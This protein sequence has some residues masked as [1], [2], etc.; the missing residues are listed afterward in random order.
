MLVRPQRVEQH[1]GMIGRIQAARQETLSAP[2]E[3]VIRE[4]LAQEGQAIEAG[5]TLLRMD[6][7]QIEIQVRQAQAELLKAQREAH[8]LRN[9]DNS[10]E[11]FRARH[12][13]QN[14]R[15]ALDVAQANLRDTRALFERGI[16]A[17]M[18]VDTLAQQVR[19]QQQDF[20]I[21]GDELRTA[22]AR[23]KGMRL[24]IAEMELTN[25]QA[26]Y[27]AVTKQRERQDLKAPFAGVVV[28]PTPQDGSKAII[29]QPGLQVTQG[30]PLLTVIGLDRIQVLARVEEA[31]LHQLL[32]GM[33][34]QITGDGFP[35]QT[36]AGRIATIAVQGNAAGAPGAAAHYD[37]VISVDAPQAGAARQAR[38]GMSARLA[39][40]L[41]RNDQGIVV[42]PQALRTD[43]EGATYVMYRATPDAAPSKTVVT[44]GRAIIQGIE[45]Q[46]LQA[47]YVL[48]PTG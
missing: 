42:P 33:P 24:K 35:G 11:V 26:R 48:V 46:G 41:Y 16:V 21:A 36:L 18:E 28:R 31:D 45:I 22:E 2:F 6:T 23:G 25:A 44:P 32:E 29:V 7:G 40:I 14:A 27:Q 17:R 10:P 12:A 3:G 5:Q 34:V 13:V 15:S 4:V 9:W 38:L 20:L 1:L 8:Q 37:V 19:R 30:A 39:V 43:D 47:G